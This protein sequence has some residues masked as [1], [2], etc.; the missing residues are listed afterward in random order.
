MHIF[1]TANSPGELAGW[2]SPL[3]KEL[4]ARDA[5]VVINLVITPCQYASGMEVQ[6]ATGM[7]EIAGV[8]RIGRLFRDLLMGR[9][10]KYLPR[11]EAGRVLFLGGD[12]LYA[13]MLA[14][15]LKVDAYAYASKP[16]WNGHFEKYFVADE[17]MSR[18]FRS[19]GVEQRRVEIVGH[20]GLDSIKIGRSRSEILARL[21]GGGGEG[22][23]KIITFLPGSR[24]VEIEVILPFFIEVAESLYE[25]SPGLRFVFAVSPFADKGQV[26]AGLAAE[27]PASMEGSEPLDVMLKSGCRIRFT[28]EDTHE[29]MSV[30][31]LAVTVPGTNTLQLAGMGIP[32]VVALPLSR[33]ELV[34]L[35]GLLGLLDPKVF[36]IGLL[37]KRLV[38]K[39][40]DRIKYVAL[41]NI[42]SERKIVPEIRGIIEPR[43]VADGV[44]RL[45]ADRRIID[46]MIGEL[47]E[48][49]QERG[50]SGKI[51]SA[52]LDPTAKSMS[53]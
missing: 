43:D 13:V 41:P 9:R 23:G 47:N 30:S 16:R 34:P 14:K 40:N 4:K 29:A 39:M 45:L 31:D 28:F 12:P 27:N 48:V 53:K 2:V 26:A 10:D 46:K 49:T 52:L 3:V 22:K 5:D 25:R 15:M 51:A 32:M 11:G 20:L 19:R 24:P 50:A 17:A 18:R 37:K 35:D 8:M 7:P 38:L 33:G 42:I 1:I 44:E 36:P 6:V 21:T